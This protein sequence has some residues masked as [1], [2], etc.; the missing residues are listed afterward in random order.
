MTATDQIV[1]VE[2]LTALLRHF[3][4]SPSSKLPG[5]YEIWTPEEGA[6]EEILVPLD[7]DRGDY[8]A[9]VERA[10]RSVMVHYGRAARDIAAVL[11]MRTSAQLDT[12]RWRKET[13]LSAGIIGWEE[14]EALYLAARAQLV[15][16]AKASK[17]PRRYH[18][19]ASAYLA[20]QFIDNSFMGQTDIGSFVITA[21]TPARR[22]LFVS[23]SAEVHANDKPA[24]LWKLNE[25]EGTLQGRVVL[26]T[27]ERSLKAI[28]AG[29]DEYRSVPRVEPFL[30]MVEDGVSYEFTKALGD[31]VRGGDATVEVERQPVGSE[32][33]SAT[34]IAFESPEAAVL[35]RVAN[36]FALDPGPQDVTL[37]GE[38]TLLSR[39]SDMPDRLVR[40]NVADGADI[41]KARVRLTAEQYELAIQAHYQDV[42]LRLSGRLEREGKLYWV[43][44][45]VDVEIV[46]DPDESGDHAPRSDPKTVITAQPPTLFDA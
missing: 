4:W 32:R 6:D 29:L 11:D 26:D 10:R 45:P 20:K 34:Q 33:G 14:G 13:A 21:H 8:N 16:S 5:R 12:T 39:A 30:D 17:E 40:L 38:V 23:R 1:P 3:E 15:A 43:Y 28:R 27:F 9:L 42:S 24:G 22:R 37:V 2:T 25:V 31:I 41:R 19:S 35:S 46:E 18:G 7:P 36:A 44:N